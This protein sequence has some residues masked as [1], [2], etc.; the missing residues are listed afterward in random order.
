M[1][2]IMTAYIVFDAVKQDPS[3]GETRL[4][5]ENA[6]DPVGSR[7]WLGLDTT[8]SVDRLLNGLIVQSGNDAAVALAEGVAGSV[9]AFVARMNAKAAELNMTSTSFANPSGLSED[10]H[11][12]TARDMALL[13][14]AIIIIILNFTIILAAE[15]LPTQAFAN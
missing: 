10:G 1:T 13:S 4:R 12:S 5:V 3:I 11:Y 7:M 8:V 6:F 2:K 9:P 14:R 15:N